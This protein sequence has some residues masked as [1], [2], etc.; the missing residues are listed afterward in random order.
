MLAVLPRAVAVDVRPARRRRRR[1][2]PALPVMAVRAVIALTEVW[3]AIPDRSLVVA[4]FDGPAVTAAVSVDVT[5]ETFTEAVDFVRRQG[6][7][8]AVVVAVASVRDFGAA[9]EAAGRLRGELAAAGVPVQ[10]AFYTHTA[11][12]AAALLDLD[13]GFDTAPVTGLDAAHKKG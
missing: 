3:G 13:S 10:G 8:R 2:M 7:D 12:G 9:L 4:A 1:R 5:D 11:R 6:G